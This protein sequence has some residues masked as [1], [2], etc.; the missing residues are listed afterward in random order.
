M[1]RS[2]AGFKQAVEGKAQSPN[3]FKTN[4]LITSNETMSGG[5]FP[6]RTITLSGVM[7]GNNR[8]EGSSKRLSDEEFQAR[9]KKELCFRCEEK[10]YAGHRCKVK[11]QKELR[12]L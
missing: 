7:A 10:Y 6:M 1:I 4:L 8:Q 5:N 2:E 11:K 9:R 12:V 3:S